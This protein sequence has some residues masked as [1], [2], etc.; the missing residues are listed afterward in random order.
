MAS[1][2]APELKLV[3][4]RTEDLRWSAFAA[5]G[6]TAVAFEAN[7]TVRFKLA[8]NPNDAP[9]LDLESGEATVNGSTVTVTAL[10]NVSINQPA[11]GTVRLAQGDTSTFRGEYHFEINLVD[12]SESQPANAIKQFLRGKLKFLPSMGGDLGL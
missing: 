1:E 8:R 2:F 12:S 5:D 3:A 9:V 4:G 7:D 6:S 10:G 11:S